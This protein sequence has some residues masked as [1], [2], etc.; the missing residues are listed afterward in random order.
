MGVSKV[1]P[2]LVFFVTGQNGLC[3]HICDCL[4]ASDPIPQEGRSVG[5]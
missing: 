1:V 3:H 2:N 4:N 5:F